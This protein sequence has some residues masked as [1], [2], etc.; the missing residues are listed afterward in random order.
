MFKDGKLD[1]VVVNV[2]ADKA[3][4]AMIKVNEWEEKKEKYYNSSGW[5]K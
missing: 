5:R 3:K 1:D 2:D 4:A